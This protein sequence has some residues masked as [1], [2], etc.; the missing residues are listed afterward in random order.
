[1]DLARRTQRPTGRA[2]SGRPRSRR[3]G[4][5]LDQQQRLGLEPRDGDGV[6]QEEAYLDQD[7]PE[8]AQRALCGLIHAVITARDTGQT[9]IN[10]AVAL[11][12]S[13]RHAVRVGLAQVRPP[14]P[15][16]QTH[17]AGPVGVLPRP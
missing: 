1:M 15:Y 14:Q 2:R 8:Q 12:T 13:F 9:D 10:P 16:R 7:W 5:A 17:R 3:G 4:E 11:I 6:F